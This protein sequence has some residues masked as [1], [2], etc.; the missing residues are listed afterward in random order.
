[1]D[2]E[3]VMVWVVASDTRALPK[4]VGLWATV[5]DEI[6]LEAEIAKCTPLTHLRIGAR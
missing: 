6:G 1:M 4:L 2:S 3:E 5:R